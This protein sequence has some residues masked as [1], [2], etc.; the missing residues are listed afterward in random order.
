[1]NRPVLPFLIPL[2]GVLTWAGPAWAS[3]STGSSGGLSDLLLLL[4]L[5]VV[6]WLA[7]HFFVERLQRT[8]L[9]SS[10]A[11]F[12]LLGGLLGSFGG[13]LHSGET[14]APVIAFATGWIGLLLGSRLRTERL[15]SSANGALRFA[16]TSAL[17]VGTLSMAASWLVLH[18]FLGFSFD[19]SI[20][21]SAFLALTLIAGSPNAARLWA[22]HFPAADRPGGLLHLCKDAA[23]ISE[24]ISVVLLGIFMAWDHPDI[25]G[26]SVQPVTAEWVLLT[27]GLG[28]GLGWLF[29][30]FLGDDR[31]R[32][33]RFLAALGVICFASGA[34]Y[35]LN[36]STMAVNLFL[37]A[38]LAN[39]SRGRSIHETLTG[40]FRPVS[41]LVLIFAGA[42][43]APVD[44]RASA[45][46]IGGM[47]AVRTIGLL[48][49]GWM[50]GIGRN[51][52]R[53][54]GRG[55]LSMGV[56]S[57]GVALSGHLSWKGEVPGLVHTAILAS[58][59]IFEL[60][61]ARTLRGLLMDAGEVD[62][63]ALV[64]EQKTRVEA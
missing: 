37:G 28:I 3:G 22:H 25:P 30:L 24:I 18:H 33:G 21:G 12:L 40:T 61:G 19:D 34:A 64:L 4:A 50:G 58:Y 56:V 1:M 59:L 10:G 47:V 27:V 43:W 45:A 29:S 42:T 38:V 17:W 53:D 15:G 9:V 51:I 62:G 44:L 14:M 57:L 11:E 5:V 2:A 55:T 35:F 8:F 39:S 36:L 13:V 48:L 49:G 31:S 7:S 26:L 16:L 20:R 63:E 52:R 46:L 32:E 41:I 54:V 6:A 60:F 23:G